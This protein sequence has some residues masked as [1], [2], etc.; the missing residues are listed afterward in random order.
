MANS[1]V[2]YNMHNDTWRFK[3]CWVCGGPTSKAKDAR[4]WYCRA[5][6]DISLYG[7]AILRRQLVVKVSA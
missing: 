3:E 4:C 1:V 6:L 2:R 7:A 5:P